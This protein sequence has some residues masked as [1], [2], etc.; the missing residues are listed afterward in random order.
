LVFDGNRGDIHKSLEPPRRFPL[1]VFCHRTTLVDKICFDERYGALSV[2]KAH[3]GRGNNVRRER[4]LPMKH[5][6]YTADMKPK[7]GRERPLTDFV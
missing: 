6:T 1:K 5:S 3:T 7:L 2:V 4:D